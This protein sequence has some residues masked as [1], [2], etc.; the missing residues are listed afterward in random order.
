MLL[1]HR[2]YMETGKFRKLRLGKF[3]FAITKVVQ[4][5]A[6][7]I[8]DLLIEKNG[9]PQLSELGPL[10][11]TLAREFLVYS[12]K[13]HK[14]GGPTD[15]ILMLQSLREDGRFDN[16]ASIATR[17]CSQM[18]YILRSIFVH[19]RRLKGSPY[20][21]VASSWESSA[22]VENRE[23]VGVEGETGDVQFG[24]PENNAASAP[25]SNTDQSN[26]GLAVMDDDD[27]IP[28]ETAIDITNMTKSVGEAF[29]FMDNDE[30]DE[31][32]VG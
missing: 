14:I 12:A 4:Q 30:D 1:R 23:V 29:E 16:D 7:S 31:D 24:H 17:A 9:N 2:M 15:F 28:L 32:L 10:V 11:H 5:A 13:P 8:Y 6:N 27:P 25:E 26:T 22:E 18:Q 19:C 3:E 20:T 21:P